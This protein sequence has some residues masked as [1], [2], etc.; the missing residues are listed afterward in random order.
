MHDDKRLDMALNGVGDAQTPTMPDGFMDG[1][2]TRVGQ[3]EEASAARRR[4]ALMGGMTVIGLGA[5]FGTIHAPAYAEMADVRLV[6]GADFS[7]AA[8]L[9]VE[10]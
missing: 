6:D 7:P 1:V 4:L 8:L 9:N 3:M 2:W 5:G 10:P